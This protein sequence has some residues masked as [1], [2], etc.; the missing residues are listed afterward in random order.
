MSLAVQPLVAQATRPPVALMRPSVLRLHVPG[1]GNLHAARRAEAIAHLLGLEVVVLKLSATVAPLVA[2]LFPQRHHDEAIALATQAAREEAALERWRHR[3][4]RRGDSTPEV[5]IVEAT[6][7]GVTRAA[8]QR[9]VRL[10]VVPPALG[11]LGGTLNRLALETHVPVLVAR[12]ARGGERV[13][14]ATNFE[15]TELPVVQQAA[16]LA[17]RLDAGLT[18]VHNAEPLAL[19]ALSFG[20]EGGVPLTVP[21]EESVLQ[22]R[23]ARLE[24]ATHRVDSHADVR[25]TRHFDPLAGILETAAS[26]DADLIVVGARDPDG[27]PGARVPERV[28]AEADRSVLLVPVR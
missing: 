11:W 9:D 14:A 16:T 21:V 20:V 27:S 7:A 28:V 3:R 18:V 8:A 15:R 6:V 5:E 19:T 4:S 23:R 2:M 24:D 1:A 26:E 22:A 12:R 25:L 17:P 10:L 13:I